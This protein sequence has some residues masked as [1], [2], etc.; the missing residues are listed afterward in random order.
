MKN[1]VITAILGIPT[2]FIGLFLGAIVLSA[3]N[4]AGEPDVPISNR[5][6]LLLVL[7][8]YFLIYFVVGVIV[9]LVIPRSGWRSGLWLASVPTVYIVVTYFT[10]SLSQG[11]V[12]WEIFRSA[13]ASVLIPLLSACIGSYLG[14]NISTGIRSSRRSVL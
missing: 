6:G 10:G 8:A 11:D 13:R 5:W 7:A 4:A 12:F 2:F 1:L 14:A 9:G 3:L